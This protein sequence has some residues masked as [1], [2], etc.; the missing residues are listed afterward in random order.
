MDEWR[1]IVTALKWT[2]L[3]GHGIGLGAFA[4]SVLR[5]YGEEPALCF[6]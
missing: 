2:S 4:E 6:K 5:Y 1:Q 3:C